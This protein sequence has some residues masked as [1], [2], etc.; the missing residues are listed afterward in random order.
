MTDGSKHEIEGVH[1]NIDGE[2]C[3]VFKYFVV[4][5]SIMVNSSQGGAVGM[6]FL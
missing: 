6:V 1:H 2:K 4:F 3:Q 5:Y